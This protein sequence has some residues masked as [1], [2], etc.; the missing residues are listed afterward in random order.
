MSSTKTEKVEPSVLDRIGFYLEC[1]K[2]YYNFDH[3]KCAETLIKPTKRTKTRLSELTFQENPAAKIN[4]SSLWRPFWGPGQQPS[5]IWSV[6]DDGDDGDDG[7]WR[8]WRR[9]DDGDDGDGS[10][11]TLRRQ[12]PAR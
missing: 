9:G 12:S 4:I 11:V 10:I 8:R 7:T 2:T 6:G 5:G 1:T 3:E